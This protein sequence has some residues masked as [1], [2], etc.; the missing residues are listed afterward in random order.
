LMLRTSILERLSGPLCDAV[1]EREGSSELMEALSR[2]NL[3]LLPLDDRGEWYRFHHLFA[4]LLRVQL[5]HREPG[6]LPALHRR[7]FVW[8][9]DNG[10]FPD[11]VEHALEAGLFAEAGRLIA[12]AWIRYVHVAR[13]ATV[14]AWLE[15]FPPELLREIPELALVEAWVLS[16]C[17]ERA[18]AAAA[19]A[20]V[21]RA[22]RL[23]AGP[24][25][26]GFSSLE[27]SLA[28]LR[29]TVPWGDTG[30]GLAN[31]RRAAELEGPASPWRALVCSALGECLY[32]SGEFDEADRWLAESAE[33]ASLHEQWWVAATA[34]GYRSLVAGERGRVD[35][36]T[37]LAERAMTLAAEHGLPEAEGEVCIAL[38][39]SLQARGKLEEALPVLEQGVAILRSVRHPQ[40]LAH[41]LIRQAAVLRAVDRRETAAEAIA[42]AR[43]AVDSCPDP[44]HLDVWLADLERPPRTQH[45][46][47]DGALS[48][49]ELVILRMLGGNLSERDIGRE[50]Y[51]S[52]NTIHSHTRSIYRKLGVSSRSEALEHARERG[53]V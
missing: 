40:N 16:L 4:Q 22:G 36:Q 53:L 19:V 46:V 9:R 24:L 30:R 41:A 23:D 33:L 48:E 43:A 5:E 21:E 50:L 38:G 42:E 7:A 32:Y 45:R 11:A 47:G 35:Q 3:F 1:L 27:A 49:R 52:Y 28:T 13:H 51:L 8:H 20:A 6:L 37:L 44:R 34:L 14:L 18:A 15:R 10:S 17:G 26:D 12:A 25:P 39:V 29:G 31:A 2:T